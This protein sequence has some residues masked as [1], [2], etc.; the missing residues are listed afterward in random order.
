MHFLIRHFQEVVD[1]HALVDIKEECDTLPDCEVMQCD[2][3]KF[4]NS[5]EISLILG[6][7]KGSVSVD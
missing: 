6:R 3:L 4:A 5:I 1:V 2:S 7:F